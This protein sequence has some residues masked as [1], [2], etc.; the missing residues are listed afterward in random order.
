MEDLLG[1]ENLAALEA[2]QEGD[3]IMLDSLELDDPDA[4]PKKKGKSKAAAKGSSAKKAAKAGSA[5]A[6]TDMQVRAT[7]ACTPQSSASHGSITADTCNSFTCLLRLGTNSA[8]SP[9]GI[10][11]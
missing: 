5:K 6:S 2:G 3:D 10:R 8:C 11:R 4:K 9:T 7:V 1:D